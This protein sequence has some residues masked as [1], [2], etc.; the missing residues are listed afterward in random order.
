MVAL[1]IVSVLISLVN[2]SHKYS[3]LT[4]ISKAQYLG[5]IQPDQL[6]AQVML[7]LDYYNNGINLVSFFWGFGFFRLAT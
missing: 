4:L 6:R 2:L 5:V 1:A 7:Q 3:V